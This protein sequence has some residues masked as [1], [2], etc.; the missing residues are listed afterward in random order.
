MADFT[1][2]SVSKGPVSDEPIATKINEHGHD[3]GKESPTPGQ[4]NKL[5]KL[6]RELK[7]RHLQMIAIG[8]SMLNFDE[9]HGPLLSLYLA[10]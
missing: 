3:M 6:K 10:C 8:E 7:S 5:P 1:N 2:S 4:P 9:R